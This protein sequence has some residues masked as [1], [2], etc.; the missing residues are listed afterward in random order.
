MMDG[1]ERGVVGWM[2]QGGKLSVNGGSRRQ[3]LLDVCKEQTCSVAT[4]R[5]TLCSLGL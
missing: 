1:N 5:S 2:E 3:S 4:S